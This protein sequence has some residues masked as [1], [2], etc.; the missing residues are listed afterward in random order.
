MTVASLRKGLRTGVVALCLVF[1][2]V[3]GAAAPA[4]GA[5]AT[6]LRLEPATAQVTSGETIK[7]AL[8]V[9]DVADLYRVE[10]HLDY[11]VF[12]LQVQDADPLR[13][14]VQIEPGPIFCATCTPW[15][16]AIDGNIHFVAQ[17]DP[18]DGPFTGSSI[19]AYI[20]LLVTATLPDSY[21]VSFDQAATRLLDS[22]GNPIAVHQFTDAL[23]NLP[24]WAT[25]TGWLTR[26]GAGNDERS[27]VNAVLYPAA[28]PYEPSSWGR[29]C[30]DAGGN[31]ALEIGYNP[32]PPPADVLPAGSPP[33]SPSCTSRWAFLRLDFTN[34]LSE[35]YWECADGDARVID[36]HDLEGGDVNGDGCINILD[37]VQIIGDYGATVDQPCHV[38]CA[39][40][41]PDAPSSN[42][43]PSC[44]INGDCQVNILD[45]TQAAGNF[46]LCSNC[47]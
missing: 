26:E 24:P 39:A 2:T 5:P 33:T 3:G 36:W 38:P 25:L 29:A 10:L 17:R 43:T 47:P 31:F 21:A 27:V 22:A 8:W 9:D 13:A 32:E 37:M 40:C 34:Y 20:T 23:L 44:D 12:G 15:N 1:V 6:G 45:L 7:L 41:P 19:A 28:P 18:G 4:R 14:S 11:D 42:V 35:C 16:E 46:G 30:T